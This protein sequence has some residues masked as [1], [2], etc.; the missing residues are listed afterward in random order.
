[1]E[2]RASEQPENA[3]LR[4]SLRKRPGFSETFSPQDALEELKTLPREEKKAAILTFREKLLA[5]E[6]AWAACR[7]GLERALEKNPDA[8]KEELMEMVEQ[9][10]ATYGFTEDQKQEAREDIEEYQRVRASVLEARRE[11]PD[12]IELVKELTGLTFEQGTSFDISTG[13][14]SV[15]IVTDVKTAD[16]IYLRTT[17]HVDKLPYSAFAGTGRNGVNYSVYKNTEHGSSKTTFTHELEHQKN[18]IF[19]ER[20][21][22][23][24]DEN[25]Q[26]ALGHWYDN[27]YNPGVKKVFAEILMKQWATEAF[28]RAKDEILAVGSEKGRSVLGFAPHLVDR[29][30]E[31][32]SYDYLRE[33]RT[34]RTDEV[35]QEASQRIL[36]DEYDTTVDKAL[37]AYESLEKFYSRKEIAGLL[38][39]K[40]LED[41]P[42]FVA[43]VYRDKLKDTTLK[44]SEVLELQRKKQAQDRLTRRAFLAGGVGVAAGLVV[45]EVLSAPEKGREIHEGLQNVARVETDNAAYSIAY[46]VPILEAN[47]ELIE[48]SDAL[49]LEMPYGPEDAELAVGNE[50][51]NT[52]GGYANTMVEEFLAKR[53][54]LTPDA[55]PPKFQKI[56][57]A[58]LEKN[59]PLYLVDSRNGYSFAHADS[60]MTNEI[61]RTAGWVAGGGLAMAGINDFAKS[62]RR[63]FLAGLGKTL[64]GLPLTLPFLEKTPRLL[65][66]YEPGVDGLSHKTRKH[67]EAWNDATSPWLHDKNLETQ[68]LLLAQKSET[69]GR[70][71]T[72]KL[73]R[74]P[75]LSLVVNDERVGIERHLKDSEENRMRSLKE[76]FGESLSEK[77]G[78][79]KV[80]G[81]SQFVDSRIFRDEAFDR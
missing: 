5:Q 25:H 43:R 9:F 54:G 51:Y 41:W 61:I 70:W 11:F 71:L 21:N 7:V 33:N 63:G 49:I 29:T 27:A 46:S 18:K 45:N 52:V 1:M 16:K 55:L 81:D 10:G 37:R 60:E 74:K 68:N 65:A 57:A 31:F 64:A 3:D 79:A 39:D 23:V 76:V 75:N 50:L 4:D 34:H 62:T 36:V 13:P 80:M 44:I 28:D 20:F 19:A 72:E 24:V 78:V 40:H 47:P 15:D 59:V 32:N 48:G 67:L 38:S 30:S 53:Y 2:K 17:D 69:L 22:R 35:W 42:K 58:A 12:D 73:G 6:E 66:P 26:N 77:A 56:I 8:P 14:M